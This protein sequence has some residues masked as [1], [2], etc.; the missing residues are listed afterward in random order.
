MADTRPSWDQTHFDCADIWS[1]RSTCPRLHVG[2]VLVDTRNIPICSGYNGAV[3][4]APH[5][6]EVGC[7]IVDGHCMRAAHAEINAIVQAAR[8]G[9]ETEGAT[10]YVT[11]QPCLNCANAIIQAGIAVVRLKGSYGDPLLFQEVLNKFKLSKVRVYRHDENG[12]MET[13]LA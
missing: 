1:K 2:A 6:T 12:E 3:R 8:I 9:A 10:L 13:S 4:N 11:Q 7:L 5:C